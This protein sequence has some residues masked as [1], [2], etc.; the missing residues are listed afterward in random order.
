MKLSVVI[1]TK[2]EEKV[3][4]DCLKSVSWADEIVV[5]DDYSTDKTAEIAKKYASKLLFRKL[6]TLGKQKRFAISQARHDW[7]LSL[8]ADE[9]VTPELAQEIQ[10]LLKGKPP[11]GAYNIYFTNHFLGHPVKYGGE[12][13]YHLRLFH[14]DFAEMTPAAIHEG[15]RAKGEVGFLKG[16]ISH[17]SYKSLRQVIKKFWQYSK[18][19]GEKLLESGAKFRYFYLV[20]YPLLDFYI[21][22]FHKRG[23]KDGIWG[24]LLA[25][26]FSFY[27]FARFWQY[28]RLSRFGQFSLDRSKE[29]ILPSGISVSVVIVSW[30]TKEV[31][32]NCLTSVFRETKNLNFEVFVVDNASTDGTVPMIK[33]EFPQARLIENSENKGFA[34]ANNQAIRKAAGEFI[35]LLNSDTIVIENAI[36]KL[37]CFARTHSDAGVVGGRLL[38]KDK[39]LQPSARNFPNIFT[40]FIEINGWHNCLKKNKYLGFIRKFYHLISSHDKSR[41]VD[42][43]S[44]A[45]FLIRKEVIEKVGLLDEHYFMYSEEMDFCFRVKKKD[46]EVYFTP[47]AEV[48]HLGGESA[49]QVKEEMLLAQFQTFRLFCQKNY[50]YFNRL[51]LDTVTKGALTG[52]RL[53]IWLSRKV[54]GDSREKQEMGAAYGKVWEA[55]S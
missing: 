45:F 22:V 12:D 32:R 54:R 52:L 49:R 33:K 11:L 43:V 18:P 7:I 9:R 21:R 1:I 28:F 10:S 40:H 50:S 20:K 47:E 51:L 55:L 26:A 14:K 29:K 6:D 15:L 37:A 2:N 30:N 53:R 5:V 3:I 48:I 16:K 25:L 38:N 27:E 4:E 19:E 35:L 13:Y 23:Y 34:A 44:G 31:T 42:W 39:T 36:E 41:K 17:Y 46:W 8:D 24:I